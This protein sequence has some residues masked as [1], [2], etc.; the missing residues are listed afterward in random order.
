MDALQRRAIAYGMA[1][2]GIQG[3][4]GTLLAFLPAALEAL[5]ASAFLIGAVMALDPL[6]ALLVLPVVS[7][8]SD[9]LGSRFGHRLPWLAGGTLLAAAG[10]WGLSTAATPLAAA[11][12]AALVCVGLNGGLG[13]YRAM[14]AEAFPVERHA[15]V[16]GLQSLL[17]EGGT[18]IA[19]GLGSWLHGRGPGWPFVAAAGLLVVTTAW[20]LVSEGRRLSPSVPVAGPRVSIRESLR[21]VPALPWLA[22]AQAAWWF[23]IQ[24]SKVFVVLFLVHEIAGVEAIASPAGREAM[25][26]AV[27]MLALTGV[28]GIA[29]SVPAGLAAARWGQGRVTM[30]GL[31]VLL[32][33]FVL[34]GFATTYPHAIALALLYGVGFAVV[35]VLSYPLLLEAWGRENL[36]AL[37][38]IANLLV[39][40]PQLVAL[41]V[42]GALVQATG[43]YRAPFWVGAAFVVVA[44]GLLAVYG[45]LRTQSEPRP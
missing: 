20:T 8:L 36:G 7:V 33:A 11:G 44:L 9:R 2:M 18:L 15:L 37:A 35:Q 21:A 1:G 27:L 24:A 13:P 40:V 14:L 19:F 22:G 12:F 39:A 31:G 26:H 3:A 43:S 23:S 41:L 42:M 4:W 34:A 38:A 25:G 6:T 5:G 16:S 32:T 29:A 30:V 10:L 17:R 28:A 45:H